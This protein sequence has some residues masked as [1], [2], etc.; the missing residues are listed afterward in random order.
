MNIAAL[1]AKVTI[2]KSV[3]TI[4]KIGNHQNSYEDYFS[5]FA[6][7][8]NSGGKSNNETENAGYVA[9]IADMN[10]TLRYCKKFETVTSTDFRIVYNDDIYNIVKVDY[11]GLKKKAI[12][13][14]CQKARR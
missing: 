10:F 13:L 3:V 7:I 2:Q 9:D 5:A 1:N 8:S 12:K 11:L 4:D 14:I 6:T